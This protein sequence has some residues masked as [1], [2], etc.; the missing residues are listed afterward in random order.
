MNTATA[1]DSTAGEAYTPLPKSMSLASLSSSAG[2]EP[3]SSSG[4]TLCG[5]AANEHDVANSSYEMRMHSREIV[6][7]DACPEEISFELAL[8]GRAAETIESVRINRCRMDSQAF[9]TFVDALCNHDVPRLRSVDVSQ[10]QVG[11]RGRAG[12]LAG[13]ALLKLLT[14]AGSIST[15]LLGWNKLELGSMRHMLPS[16]SPGIEGTAFNLKCLDLRANPLN[17]QAKHCYSKRAS[18]CIACPAAES[19]EAGW[20]SMLIDCMPHL[21][22]IQLAQ[23]AISD[24]MLVALARF[25]TRTST[26]VEYIGLEWLGLGSRL[27]VLRAILGNLASPASV[28][29]LHLNLASNNLGDSGM[30]AISESKAKLTSLTLSCNFI[31]ERGAAYLARWLPASG[32]EDLDLSDNHFGDQGVDALVAMTSSRSRLP[33][34]G[35]CPEASDS[36]CFYTQIKSLGLTSCCLGDTSLRLLSRALD[37]RWAPLVSLRILRNSRI[38]PGTKL[39]I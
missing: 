7:E 34:G 26:K 24:S 15:L 33:K 27:S 9:A 2:S 12:E 21:T 38:S 1:A 3:S 31:T 10:N 29:S 35:L 20:L 4:H 13:K 18:Q 5:S 6:I 30:L 17:T 22:H 28:R 37:C 39:S 8:G 11:G 25:L 14:H 23:A 16:S 32:L 36:R 19:T